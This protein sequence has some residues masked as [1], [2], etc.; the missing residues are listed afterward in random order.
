MWQYTTETIINSSNGHLGT[1]KD[2]RFVAVTAEN[3]PVAANKTDGVKLL[4][5][6]VGSF[7]KDNIK[8]IYRTK[9]QEAAPATA[10]VAA[11]AAQPAANTVVRLQVW[12]S[13]EGTIR[14]ELQNAML[15]KSLPFQFEVVAN[16]NDV[17]KQ[18]VKSVEKMFAK[19]G[20][21][22]LFTVEAVEVTGD[23]STKKTQLVFKAT[24]CYVQF[25]EVR[26]DEVLSDV[27]AL[28]GYHNYN[29]LLDE[30]DVTIV[31]GT[32][33]NGTVARLVKN[34]RIP[35]SASLNPF[36]SYQGG[37]PVPGGK[38]HQYLIQYVVDRS[39]M[40][41]QVFGSVG[42]R[43]MT[44]HVLFIEDGADDAFQTELAKLGAWTKGA[45]AKVSTGAEQI[46]TKR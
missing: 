31:R 42:D 16:G 44:S 12:V 14:P 46:P 21:D 45:D 5:E 8:A 39:H 33:G 15:K 26:I 10:T 35:T 3:K 18:L 20:S 29:A 7:D 19:K 2:Q 34:L 36:G 40:G 11:L 1:N 27:G 28:N 17:Y 22:K 37:K 38:Y 4:I 6:G 24:D 43:S 30:D 25:D 41:H 23:G 13:E 32:E 9:H